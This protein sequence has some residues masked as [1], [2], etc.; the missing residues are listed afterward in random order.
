MSI[1]MILAPLFVQVA[2]TFALLFWTGRARV[3]L[4]Q[5]GDVHPRDIALREANWPKR[6]T[7]LGNAYQNQ[8]EL[9]VL[10]YVLTILAIITRHADL[11]FVLLAWVFVVLRVVHATVHVTSNR[12]GQRFA[13]FAAAAAVLL[14]MWIIFAVRILL[15]L[16]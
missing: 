15:G 10:F 2:L 11:L 14:A 12:L 7:Q 4:V 5:R 9:P 13:V 3:G 8:L 16:P 6:E 1:P